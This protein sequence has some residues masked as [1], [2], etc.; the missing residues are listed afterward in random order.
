MQRFFTGT[1]S[2]ELDFHTVLKQR[3]ESTTTS[4]SQTFV[5]TSPENDSILLWMQS[6]KTEPPRNCWGIWISVVVISTSQFWH[7]SRY[8]FDI[9]EYIEA[10]NAIYNDRAHSQKAPKR[11]NEY[12]FREV[13]KRHLTETVQ[14]EL[15]RTVSVWENLSTQ[16]PKLSSLFTLIHCGNRPQLAQWVHLSVATKTFMMTYHGRNIPKKIQFIDLWEN[17]WKLS[18]RNTEDQG[19]FQMQS[20]FLLQQNNT[21]TS[22]D[23]LYSHPIYNR[24][25]KFRI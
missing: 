2:R 4:I 12:G 6:M 3:R 8:S 19:H 24:L 17:K 25:W 13:I 10:F 15:S 21:Y 18:N 5:G 11:K 9:N 22:F 20:L 23:D 14:N 7:S 1:V 16:H